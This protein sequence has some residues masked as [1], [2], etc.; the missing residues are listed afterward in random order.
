MEEAWASITEDTIEAPEASSP[1]QNTPGES[2]LFREMEEAWDSTTMP[3]VP[4]SPPPQ[5]SSP[6]ADPSSFFHDSQFHSVLS[7]SSISSLST[8]ISDPSFLLESPRNNEATIPQ[9]PSGAGLTTTTTSSF[10][11][12][13]LF[14]SPLP[15][16]NDEST[17]VNSRL[18]PSSTGR[19]VKRVRFAVEGDDEDEEEDK[20]HSKRARLSSPPALS[21]S[22]PTPARHAKTTSSLAPGPARRITRSATAAAAAAAAA[23]LPA[24]NVTTSSPV[25]ASSPSNLSPPP[26]PPRSPLPPST[27]PTPAAPARSHRCLQSRLQADTEVGNDLAPAVGAGKSVDPGGRKGRRG[28]R[29]VGGEPRGR[30]SEVISGEEAG[31]AVDGVE[32]HQHQL[33]QPAVVARVPGAKKSVGP[34]YDWKTRPRTRWSWR[35]A[36]LF[37]K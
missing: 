24:V 14:S 29:Q 11:A 20:Q 33:Q 7:S 27:S 9:T 35:F 23:A 1:V 16:P 36:H 5:P 4:A 12:F 10:A 17:P 19:G 31:N 6:S 22:S 15:T 28:G 8:C 26:T 34:V 30:R 18:P 32:Q 2:T 13:L 37:V 25:A 3:L 21:A